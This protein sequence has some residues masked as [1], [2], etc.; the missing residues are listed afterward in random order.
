M[1]RRMKLTAVL[2]ALVLA[3][4]LMPA[5][6]AAEID[7]AV[8]KGSVTLTLKA[9]GMEATLYRVGLGKVENSNLVFELQDALAGK[10]GDLELNSLKAAQVEAV[11]EKLTDKDLDL[12]EIL[13]EENVW[14]ARAEEKTEEGYTVKLDDMPVGVYLVVQS[15]NNSDFEDFDPFLLYLPESINGGWNAKVEAEPKAEEIEYDDPEDPE[16]PPGPPPEDIPDNPPPGDPGDPGDPPEEIPEEEVPLATLP[17]T[18]LLQWPVPVMAMAGLVLFMFG[19]A[20]E[21]RRKA[22]ME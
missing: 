10:V 20:S 13:G 22:L 3:V 9:R 17:Q 11:V 16:D 8:D 12:E 19:F 15:K 1:K 5:A 14:V 18:G 7:P 6:A 2:L 4:S 21:K